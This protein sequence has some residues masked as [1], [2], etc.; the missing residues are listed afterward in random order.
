VVTS[1][2]QVVA[3]NKTLIAA[4]K[5]PDRWDDFLKP[6]FKGR[7]FT[8][9]I[10]PTEI[11]ALVPAWGLEKTLAF[12]RKIA[13]QQPV[14]VRGGTRTVTAIAAGEYPMFLGPNYHS[15]RRAQEKDPTK[16]L[17]MKLPE[18]IP[19]RLSDTTAV[20]ASAAHPYAALLWLEFL[21]SPKG[22]KIADENEPYGASLFLAGS[23]QE[24][25]TRGKKLSLV[26]W[27]HFDKMQ[28]YQEK[29]VEAYGFPKA[30]RK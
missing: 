8:A 11:A 1:T 9:D 19:T 20:F 22:Q 14:W 12:S 28:G 21:V 29:V 13:A 4:E 18:P 2:L 7:K 16:N 24:S 30:D 15:V 3:Y 23:A 10:R 17:G 27:E 6:E 26:D 25:V 5:V